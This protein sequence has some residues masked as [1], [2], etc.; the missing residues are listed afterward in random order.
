MRPFW[1]FLVVGIVLLAGC[2]TTAPVP[3]S[4]AMPDTSATATPAPPQPVEFVTRTDTV[5]VLRIEGPAA[6]DSTATTGEERFAVQIGAFKAPENASQAQNLAR[7]RYQ[8]PVL[9][10]FTPKLAL[11]QIRI[12]SF[13][14]REEARAFLLRM[15]SEHPVDYK[16]SWIVQWKR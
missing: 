16:D 8:I 4:S 3:E 14:S 10:E 1:S 11:Y 6:T 2:S 15:Q 12:G 7:T 9:N 13:S 5:D